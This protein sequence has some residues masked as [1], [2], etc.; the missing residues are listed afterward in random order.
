M[1]R[2]STASIA[3]PKAGSIL[4]TGL[5]A[6]GVVTVANALVY[7]VAKGLGV[8]FA[9]PF[10]PDG[11]PM[12]L[13]VTMVMGSS[14]G[15]AM[16]A[17]AAC[18]LFTRWHA[19]GMGLF[20]TVGTLFL[21]TSFAGPLTSGADGATQFTLLLMHIIAGVPIIALLSGVERSSQR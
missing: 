8:S 12:A 18:L 16:L 1:M 17:T 4:R 13:P 10:A 11:Q 14:I 21:L 9:G 6:A 7:W 5:V 3:R 19:R 15:G 20:K 2:E